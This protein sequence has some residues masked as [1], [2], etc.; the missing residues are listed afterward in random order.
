[1]RDA[2]TPVIR[3]E[4]LGGL[5]NQLFQAAAGLAL[6]MRLG[7]QLEFDLWR[8][9]KSGARSYAMEGLGH[10]ALISGHRQSWAGRLAH[11]TWRRLRFGRPGAPP[12]WPGDV[13]TEASFAYDPRIE[14]ISGS[15]YLSGYFQSEKYFQGVSQDVRER[16][17]LL[18]LVSAPAKDF[19]KRL[20][21]DTLA[22][23]VRIGDFRSE[24]AFTQVHGTLDA[25]YYRQ[26]L[27]HA[28]AAAPAARI[29]VFS[30]TPEAIPNLMPPGAS[31]E[32]VKGF[33]AVDDMYLMAQ[34]RHHI[35]ANS[36]FSWWSAW[37]DPRPDK[38][39]ICP[40]QWFAADYLKNT[41]IR[42]LFPAGWITL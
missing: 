30:D 32:I 37:F 36:T 22:V 33:P 23:H 13:L 12:F 38:L 10:G 21:G 1:M 31:Y 4:L 18:P 7:G 8:F 19:A 15:C 28:L 40:K 6:A 27:A 41:D 3:V 5:G 2:M 26:A 20:T 24:T 14:A 42:D 35:I 16:L 17:S 34:A 25:G 29:F 9:R 39:V 11:R